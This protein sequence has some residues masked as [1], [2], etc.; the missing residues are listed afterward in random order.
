MKKVIAPIVLW[1]AMAAAPCAAA[2][3]RP[4]PADL[5]IQENA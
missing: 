3:G 2:A 5:Q 4:A 1:T